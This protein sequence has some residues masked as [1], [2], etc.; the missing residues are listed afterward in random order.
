M[1]NIEFKHYIFLLYNYVNK[2]KKKFFN[3][4]KIQIL[5]NK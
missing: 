1:S 2:L 4:K 3:L 5:N